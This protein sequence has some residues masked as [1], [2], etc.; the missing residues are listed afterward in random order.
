MAWHAIV[1]RSDGVLV[2]MATVVP[3]SLPSELEAVVLPRRIDWT[4][5]RWD[6]ATRTIAAKP[7]RPPDI[8]RVND[9]MSRATFLDTRLTAAQRTQF[10]TILSTFLGSRRFRD[11]AEP[12]EL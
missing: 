12:V 7:A 2:S 10:R 5:E 11:S 6:S 1:R 9:F 4:V 3:D 8:D